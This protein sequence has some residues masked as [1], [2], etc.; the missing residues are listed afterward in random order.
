MEGKQ[1]GAKLVVVDPRMSNTAS[2]AD[3]WLAP[4]AGQRGRDAAGGRLATCCAPARSTSPTCGAGST[5]GPTWPSATPSAEPTFEAFLDRLEADYAELHVRVRRRGGAGP[6]R[7]DPSSWPSWSRSATTGC[8]R[9]SGGRRP[10]ATS[11]AGRSPAAMWFVLALT[12]SIGTVGGTSPNGWNKFIPHGPDVPRARPLERAAWPAEYPMSCNE[13]SILLP[14]FLQEGRGRLEVYFSRVF[15]PIWTYPD[16]FTWMRALSDP[17]QGRTARRADPDLVGD[18]RVRR[19][20]PADGALHRAP[21]HPLLRDPRRRSGSA[22]GNRSARGDGEARP[23]VSA[24]PATPTRARCGRRT[25]SGSSCPGA[26]TPTGRLGIRQHFESPVP[27][28]ARRSPSTSTTG[29]SSRTGCRACWRRPRPKGL[30]PLAV[31]APLR[32]RRGR[33]RDLYRQDERPLTAAEL[34]GAVPDAEPDTPG[35]L[36]KPVDA[37]TRSRR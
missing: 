1:A 33:R 31:H 37:W 34:D 7:A 18:R 5:G 22:S 35:V 2:H 27:R 11:A 30:T 8:P 23:P 20:R 10:R 15:N 6:G 4:V 19:L 28:R 24:T 32:R 21:R 9:T 17:R 16:G 14:H 26:S 3:L 13:M 12:G 25:S 36:R 29:G